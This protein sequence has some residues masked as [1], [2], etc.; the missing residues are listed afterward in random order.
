MILNNH[1]NK[2]MAKK[3]VVFILI[4][5]ILG[6][7]SSISKVKKPIEIFVFVLYSDLNALK[8]TITA[9]REEVGD[10]ISVLINCAGK[11]YLK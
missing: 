10:N 1:F 5:V 2:S 8:Y 7:F 4:D 3:V 11:S 9:I 6:L